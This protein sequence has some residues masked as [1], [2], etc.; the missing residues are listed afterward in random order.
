MGKSCVIEAP[1]GSRP[2]WSPYVAGSGIGLT[3]LGT[4][5]IMGHGL[6]ASG[7]FTQAAASF[8]RV[9]AP[10][11]V[12]R[13]EYL[14]PFV[15]DGS[16]WTSWIVIEVLGVMAG[17]F[18]SAWAAGRLQWQVGKGPSLGR[19]SRIALAFLGG[20]LTGAG[21]RFAQ[22]CTSGQILSG[23]SVFALGSWVFALAFFAGGFGAAWFV[24]RAWR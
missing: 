5:L 12:Q 17:A 22:G 9:L 18:L 16:F 13:S 4:Y 24:G 8:L 1:P 21:S 23:G 11:H 2:Y 14:S 20:I 10:E 19:G 6:G 3:L 7:A 15:E